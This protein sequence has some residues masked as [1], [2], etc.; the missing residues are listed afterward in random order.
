MVLL[1]CVKFRGS[2]HDAIPDAAMYYKSWNGFNDELVWS[3]IWLWKITNDSDTLKDCE[4]KYIEF[5]FDK[6]IAYE[7]S[8]SNKIAG[9]QVCVLSYTHIGIHWFLTSGITYQ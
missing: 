6:T 1:S 8:W 5:G 4:E 2:Y 9:A 3:C 7:F